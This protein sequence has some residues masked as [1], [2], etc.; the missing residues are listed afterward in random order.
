[1]QMEEGCPPEKSWHPP[2]SPVHKKLAPPLIGYREG[3]KANLPLP[4]D[5]QKLKASQLQGASTPDPM[6]RGSAAGQK[7]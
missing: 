4:L 6:T 2:W 5:V 3:N 7:L 1:V